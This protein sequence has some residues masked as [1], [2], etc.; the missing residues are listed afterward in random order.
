MTNSSAYYQLAIPTDGIEEVASSIE[1]QGL[2]SVLLNP[3]DRLVLLALKIRPQD[4]S[5]FDERT[6]S[7]KLRYLMIKNIDFNHILRNARDF[8]L[9]IKRIRTEEIEDEETEIGLEE[10][11]ANR[12]YDR[13]IQIIN[14]NNIVIKSIEGMYRSAEIIFYESGMI[15][16]ETSISRSRII[17]NLLERIFSHLITR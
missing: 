6:R 3:S 2:D 14:D 13:C 12:D 7:L 17:K 10:A 9:R 1:R 11:I 16:S 8:N 15:W 4:L 5:T